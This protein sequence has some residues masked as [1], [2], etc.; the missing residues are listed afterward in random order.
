MEMKAERD[1]LALRLE[2]YTQ[3]GTWFE[4]SKCLVHMLAEK[5]DL[6]HEKHP[7]TF[8]PLRF[9]ILLPPSDDCSY[10]SPVSCACIR[11]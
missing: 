10:V 1:C 4:K 3:S 6:G 5:G 2:T 9:E 8:G 11:T 7:E